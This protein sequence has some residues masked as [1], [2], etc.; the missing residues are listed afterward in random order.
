MEYS[1]TGTMYSIATLLEG[2]NHVI[3]EKFEF[4]DRDHPT[5]TATFGTVPTLRFPMQ[6]T[7]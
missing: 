6:T 4:E 7:E 3:T 2:I 5:K 1:S